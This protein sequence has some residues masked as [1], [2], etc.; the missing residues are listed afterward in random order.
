MAEQTGISWCDATF[1]PWVGCSKVSPGCA[2]CYAET[3]VTGRMGRAGTWGDDGVRERTSPGLWQKP[4][5]WAALAREGRLPNGD[6]NKDG[7]RPRVFCASLADVF[8][9]RPELEP[10]R[11]DLFAL[12]DATPELDWLVLTKRP[13]HALEW[14]EQWYVE[15]GV[16]TGK[17]VSAWSSRDGLGWGCPQNLW[18]G[19]SIENSRHTFRADILRQIPAPVR[20]ISAEPLLG[21]LFQGRPPGGVSSEPGRGLWR[22]PTPRRRRQ[23]DGFESRP[24]HYSCAT[25]SGRHRLGDRRR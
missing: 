7:H 9:P 5:H 22:R 6:E 15:H 21:S 25:R 11:F 24:L 10:W 2:H 17:F 16:R 13:D 14:L 1:N 3:L 18:M 4:T 19:V 23:L 20:F 12:I 8:E